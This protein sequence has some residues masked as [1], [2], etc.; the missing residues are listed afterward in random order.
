MAAA[1]APAAAL[2]E[3]SWVNGEL[4]ATVSVL[5]RG[6]HYGDGL[7]ETI[8][9]IDGRPRLFQRHLTRLVAGAERL[10]LPLERAQVEGEVRAAASGTSRAILKVLL[11]RGP[12]LARGYGSTGRETPTRI[13]LQYHWPPEHACGV[14]GVR[15]RVG[16]LRLG[17]N[18][19]LAGLKHLNRLE[20]VLARR[21]WSDPGIA[22][23]LMFSSSERLISGT[24]CNV[25]LVK[26]GGLLTPRLDRCG[27]AGVMRASVLAL[28]GKLAV[29]VSE[30]ELMAVDLASA[31]ELF[32]TNALIGI[33]AVREVD[34]R[35]IAVGPVT[36]FLRREL[37]ARLAGGEDP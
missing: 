27:V 15:V 12:A 30:T 11:A 31:Q 17:E 26:D 22:D 37:T 23:A 24:M 35:A 14:Q 4:A 19:A 16:A 29:P 9:C 36:Q 25:F 13:T 32:L 6:L 33:C 28:A 20:Q 1:P 21:E 5:E 18:P 8:A 34:G 7:F 2:L 10:G 3:Q